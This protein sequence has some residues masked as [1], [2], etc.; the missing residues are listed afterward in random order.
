MAELRVGT[1]A[2]I[3]QG[4]NTN[5]NVIVQV[6]DKTRISID[7][8]PLES[9]EFRLTLSDSQY[10]LRV[11]LDSRINH[12]LSDLVDNGYLRIRAVVRREIYGMR[13]VVVTGAHVVP[14]EGEQAIVGDPQ[15]LDIDIGATVVARWITN[16][17]TDYWRRTWWHED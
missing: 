14:V 3:L 4:T 8:V 12:V 6:I 9:E 11:M 16:R 13:V 5:L 17:T 15:E 1:C 2:Q 7:G 10:S